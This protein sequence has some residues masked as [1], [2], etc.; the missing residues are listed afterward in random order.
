MPLTFHPDRGTIVIYD[1]ST[2]FQPPEMVKKRPVVIV[3]PRLRGRTGLC[4]VVPLST[5]APDP[6]ENYHYLLKTPPYP[7]ASSK[8]VWAKC[9]MITTVGLARMDRIRIKLSNGRRDYRTFA[10]NSADLKEVLACMRV[11]LG[12]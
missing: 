6:V 12:I 7:Q 1:F 5:T 9:D 2:G 4:T 10:M 3:S 8:D 11:A